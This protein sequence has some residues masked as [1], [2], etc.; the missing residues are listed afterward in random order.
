MF[1]WGHSCK[2]LTPD[3]YRSEHNVDDFVENEQLIHDAFWVLSFH[4]D[5][6]LDQKSQKM[7]G[8]FVYERISSLIHRL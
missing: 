7:G 5:A 3:F 1:S 8:C 6:R 4:G 2:I